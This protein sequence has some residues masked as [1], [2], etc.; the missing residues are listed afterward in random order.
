[1]NPITK[2]NSTLNQLRS[3]DK[4]RQ[5]EKITAEQK[6]ELVQKGLKLFEAEARAGGADKVIINGIDIIETRLINS[7]AAQR[8]GYAF[9]QTSKN[10]IQLVKSLK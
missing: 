9:E 2:K 8:L 4:E 5:I 10:S 6:N 3:F 7:Q 1:M